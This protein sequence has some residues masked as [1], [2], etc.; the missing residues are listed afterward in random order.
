MS[1]LKN[2]VPPHPAELTVNRIAE[3][4]EIDRRTA[5][6]RLADTK[7]CRVSGKVSFYAIADV[8]EAVR[9]SDGLPKGAKEAAQ[10]QKILKQIERLDL[11]NSAIRGEYLK[12]SDVSATL[13]AI[14]TDQKLVLQR[15]LER[16][17]PPKLEGLR[18]EGIHAKM[19]ETV[20]AICVLFS[21]ASRPYETT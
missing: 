3:I 10:V 6:R 4:F 21:D 1:K 20:D 5:K 11:Q 12:A 18:A 2:K 16:E 15:I 14:A 9:P 7:P 8:L 19:I 13:Q 17:L